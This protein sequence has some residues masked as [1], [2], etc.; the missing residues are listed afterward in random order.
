MEENA[1]G[2]VEAPVSEA[3][4]QVEAPARDYEAEARDMGWVPQEEYRGDPQRW[5]PADQF[6]KDGEKILPIVRSQNKRLKEELEQTRKEF[7]ERAARIERMSNAALERQK[8]QHEAELARIKAAQ[9]AAVE[10]GDTQEF[11]RLDVIREKMAKQTFDDPVK[12]T[13]QDNPEAVIESWRKQNDWY[14]ND[15]EM[16][17]EA[18]RYSQFVAKRNPSISMADNLKEVEQH[19]RKKFPEKFG[20]KPAAK[21]GHA[22]V[23]GGGVFGAAPQKAGMAAKLPDEAKAQAERDVKAG[24]YKSAEEWAKVYFA[25]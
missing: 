1:I 17:Q 16:T 12:E 4:A 18:E 22:A 3:P 13:K 19:M 15:Y 25:N 20:G 7:A 24:L 10:Q 8:A 2:A 14:L 6:V 23:D 21:N 5:K 11:E 9:R